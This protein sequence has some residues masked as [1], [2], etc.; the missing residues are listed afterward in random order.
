MSASL[1]SSLYLACSDH[2]AHSS[3][4]MTANDGNSDLQWCTPRCPCLLHALLRRRPSKCT[5]TRAPL[6]STVNNGGADV[7][8]CIPRCRRRLRHL[9][10]LPALKAHS[11]SHS[12]ALHCQQ[13]RR[14]RPVVHSMLSLPSLPSPLPP[15][16][17]SALALALLGSP[18]NDGDFHFQWCVPFC[19]SRHSLYLTTTLLLNCC[20]F[21]LVA[22]STEA[23]L[24]WSLPCCPSC[25]CGRS[26]VTSTLS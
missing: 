20:S 8:W 7:Q 3:P 6:L 23:Y 26:V 2:R 16:P 1:L 25:R 24:Q 9:L 5:H 18:V 17:Q 10:C 11:H 22:M 12:L 21:T 14:Q 4:P 13:R 19:P 15:G